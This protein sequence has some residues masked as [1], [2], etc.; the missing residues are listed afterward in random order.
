MILAQLHTGAELRNH[1]NGVGGIGS[2]VEFS[3]NVGQHL[4]SETV[5]VVFKLLMFNISIHVNTFHFS[6]GC[7]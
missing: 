2:V 6:V 5:C 4:C 7:F 3:W 1:V